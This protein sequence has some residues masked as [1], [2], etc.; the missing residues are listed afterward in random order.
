MMKEVQD[1]P[2]FWTTCRW[3]HEVE[4]NRRRLDLVEVLMFGPV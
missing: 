1:H 2:G 3:S 4:G